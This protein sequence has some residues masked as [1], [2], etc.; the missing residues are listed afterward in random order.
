VFLF[1]TARLQTKAKM[2]SSISVLKFFK[3]GRH[4]KEKSKDSLMLFAHAI[5]TTK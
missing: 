5:E 1:T 4:W 3:G 2:E